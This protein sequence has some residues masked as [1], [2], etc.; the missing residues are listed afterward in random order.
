[1]DKSFAVFGLGKFGRSVATELAN[2]G[3]DV[4]A[5]DNDKERVHALADVVTCAVA[6]D[7]RDTEAM[8]E[9]GISNMDAVV[10]AITRSLDASILATIFAKEA[11]V[12]YVIA[13]SQDETHSKILKKV[14]ADKVVR[15]ELE[16]GIRIARHLATGNIL[17]FVELSETIK[18]LEIN[19]K[20]DWAGCTLRELDL[21]GKEHINVIAIRKDGELIVNPD[22]DSI[23]APDLSMLITVEKKYLHRLIK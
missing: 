22:P 19:I 7:I 16:T 23:L 9:L 21:R 18:M 15:P 2:A 11:G 4:L 20:P 3:A 5:I 13:K 10:V 8:E 12:P 17:D 14:G 1:M 6:A